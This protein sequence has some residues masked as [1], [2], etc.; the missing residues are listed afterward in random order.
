MKIKHLSLYFGAI[1]ILTIN[2]SCDSDN[3]QY[4]PKNSDFNSP[5]EFQ[6]NASISDAIDK[7]D[8]NLYLG[9]Y[10]P[11]IMGTYKTFG[12]I[13]NTS[14]SLSSYIG[15]SLGST[16]FFIYDQTELGRIKITEQDG[17]YV[18]YGT[19]GYITG[20]GQYFTI[21]QESIQGEEAGLPVGVTLY[22]SFI[23]SGRKSTLGTIE[24]AQFL[25]VTT[26]VV[27]TNTDYDYHEG[28][29]YMGAGYM[30]SQ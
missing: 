6:N 23:L 11:S 26:S 14:S 9:N 15:Q 19:G 4:Y 8:F 16:T 27:S 30:N 7:S 24:E 13:L 10:P 1:L 12:T 3:N 29:W 21:Y 20:D 18:A 17:E 25:N 28:E 22:V 2:T 5:F